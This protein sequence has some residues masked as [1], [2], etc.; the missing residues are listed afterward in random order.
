MYA[1]EKIARIENK[2]KFITYFHS[3]RLLS[4]ENPFLM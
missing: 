2:K 1:S 3:H 4:E